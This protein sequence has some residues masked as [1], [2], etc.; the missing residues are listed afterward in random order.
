MMTQEDGNQVK[1]AARAYTHAGLHVLPIKG[2]GSK[3]PSVLSWKEYQ[4]RLARQDE[5]NLWFDGRHDRGVAVLGGNGLEVLDFDRPGLFERF[6][7]LARERDPGLVARL[8]RVSTPGG[9][10]HLYYYCDSVAPSQKLARDEGGKTLIETRGEGGYVLAPPSP[11]C[12]HPAHKPY[13]HVAGPGLTATPRISPAERDILLTAAGSFDRKGKQAGGQAT[14]PGLPPLEERVRKG[15]EYVGKAPLARSGH[16]GHNTT[17]AVSRR[18][19]NDLALP[20]DE[21]RC[22]L[23]EYNDRLAEAG[24][25]PWTEQE[26]DH[27]VESAGGD[28]P[29]FPYGGGAAPAEPAND[30]YRL[31]RSFLASRPWVFWHGRHFEYVGTRYVEVPDYEVA[32]LLAGHVKQ[33]L[34]AAYRDRVRRYGDASRPRSAARSPAIPCRPSS[35]C[36]WYACPPRCPACCPT[37]RRRTCWPWPTGCS[38]WTPSSCDRTRPTGS[39]WPAC[40][41]ATT[42]RPPAPAGCRSWARTWRATPNASAC[43]RSS[44]ATP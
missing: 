30:P 36:A 41:T 10:T 27:K 26:L 20:A 18:L 6:G 38:T 13:V 12:C 22:L 7:A 37:A 3:Q 8:P 43:C 34:D 14:L 5:L 33:T 25:E 39:R 29:D 4:G 15:R 11:A 42:R 44:S 24:E 32:A 40:P 16:G 31:A 21:A 23:D 17:Y 28:R 2:D 9:G 19:V 1:D 35:R